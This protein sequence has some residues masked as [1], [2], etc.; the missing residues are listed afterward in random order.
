M[1]K[2]IG[3]LELGYEV[4]GSGAALLLLHAFPLDRRMWDETAAALAVERRVI[5]LD[6]RGFGESELGP[7]DHSIETLADDAVALLDALGVPMATVAGLSMGGYVALALA[8]RHPAR[9]GGLILAD[10]RA[11]ADGAEARR[12]RDDSI[13]RVE[14]DGVAPLADGLTP[15]L[16]SPSAPESLRRRVRE[17]ALPQ[18]P[19]SVIA[20]LRALRDRPDRTAELRDI[21]CPTLILVGGE[22]AIT[23]PAEARAMAAAIPAARIVELPAAGH[24]SNLESPAAFAAAINSFLKDL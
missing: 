5:A 20:A 7:G 24:L 2:R 8:R 15:R 9:L 16:L 6:A 17:L 14:R 10:T 13:A 18:S 19:A 3:A 12:G 23:P 4:R 22:D 1:R 11:G 21:R